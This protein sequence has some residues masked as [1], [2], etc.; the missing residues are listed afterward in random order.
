MS[1]PSE[2]P[3]VETNA[4]TQLVSNTN[5]D[6]SDKP[7]NRLKIGTQREGE[8]TVQPRKQLSAPKITKTPTETKLPE[9]TVYKTVETQTD[10]A[11][12]DIT[13][14]LPN[15][16]KPANSTEESNPDI[17]QPGE[18]PPDLEA[19]IAAALEDQSL[20]KLLQMESTS[21]KS[22]DE[23]EI[24]SRY[25]ATVVKVDRENVFFSLGEQHEAVTSTKNF[26][27]PPAVGTRMEVVIIGFQQDDNLYEVN[28]PGTSVSVADWSD[29]TEGV[30]VD[31]MVTGH[32]QG[33]LE[34]EV[35]HIRGFIPASQV[36]L[37][38]VEDL[39]QFTG[40]KLPCVVTEA[41][42]RRNNLVLS[43]RAVLEREKEKA[44]EKL[45]A[46]LEVGQERQGIV[47]SL[48]KFGA[49]VD[50]GGVDGLIH[51]S[52]LSWDR[53]HHPSDILEEGQ[54]VKVKIDKI[55]PQTGKLSLTYRDSQDDPWQRVEQD[56][57]VQSIVSGRVSKIMD[58]GAFVRLGP[59]VEGLV[60]VS[61]LVHHRVSRV[62]Q[63]VQE[64]EPIDV[65]VL[66]IDR[67]NQRISLSRK[68]AMAAAP[69]ESEVTTDED[70]DAKLPSGK[71][72]IPSR[73]QPL[74]GGT[75]RSSGGDLFGLK[76]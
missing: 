29:L 12:I 46:E 9:S 63:V 22:A 66:S 70:T 34:C 31:A 60:H 38:R 49:F 10:E 41:N 17:P 53:V 4:Q 67:E 28:I 33:G 47:R 27:Q 42:S 20:D 72:I 40:E 75:D 15:V 76:W 68:A 54:T 74:K 8:T 6:M 45:L 48:Q 23:I 24:E 25:Q 61:E 14:I 51:I 3:T 50:L 58:F 32:N 71:P 62:S 35:N 21:S 43:H 64:G 7:G 57:P 73:N 11:D 2:Q 65:K 44:R 69:A 36:S 59:G 16:I 52:K 18:L 56:F 1:E 37:F 13:E 26:E 55:D 30:I 19:E 5:R 39:S